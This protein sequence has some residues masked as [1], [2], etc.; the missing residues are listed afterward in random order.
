MVLGNGGAAQPVFHYMKLHNAAEV[1]VVKRK[2]SSGVI[3][4]EDAL[5]L[6]SDADLIINT[7]PMGMFPKVDE[8]PMT[9]DG[10][11]KLSAVVDLVAN[12][13]E[14]KLMRFAKEK[15]IPTA[16]GLEMLVAQAKLAEELFR[17]IKIP[18]EDIRNVTETISKIMDE[19]KGKK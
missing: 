7:S 17:D 3:D 11:Y 13:Q 16:G 5:A 1:I 18:R 2:A 4:Y 14:T 10:Y 19:R 15:N 9:L 6:H 8:S 12:P